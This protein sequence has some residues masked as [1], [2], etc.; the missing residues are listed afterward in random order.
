M[1]MG[2]INL[3]L[4]C[5]TFTTYWR[6]EK[7]HSIQ[8]LCFWSLWSRAKPCPGSWVLN[9]KPCSELSKNR[10]GLGWLMTRESETKTSQLQMLPCVS[11]LTSP[12][13][14][15]FSLTP[16]SCLLQGQAGSHMHAHSHTKSVFSV[17]SQVALYVCGYVSCQVSKCLIPQKKSKPLLSFQ[18]VS[19]FFLT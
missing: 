5:F 19:V 16:N 3:Y 2:I 1:Q 9:V 6:G 14:F 4:L 8:F 15:F 18:Q 11:L 10:I 7:C 13:P 12:P 17:H